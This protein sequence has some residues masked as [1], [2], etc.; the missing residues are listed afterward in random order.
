MYWRRSPDLLGENSMYRRLKKQNVAVILGITC[1]AMLAGCGGRPDLAKRIESVDAHLEALPKLHP[2]ML[3][4]TVGFGSKIYINPDN[5][6][7]L[8]VILPEPRQ[9]D[10]IVLIP[11]LLKNED[12]ELVTFGFP[13]R[14]AIETWMD[15]IPAT[16]GVRLSNGGWIYQPIGVYDPST[17]PGELVCELALNPLLDQTAVAPVSVSLYYA[18][19]FAP[20]N[21]IDV[22]DEPG[23]TQIGKAHTLQSWADWSAATEK[24]VS[25][26]VTACFDLQSV[27]A[28]A[29][30]FLRISTANRHGGAAVDNIK[31]S[32]PFTLTNGDFEAPVLHPDALNDDVAGWYNDTSERRAIQLSTHQVSPGYSRGH[33]IVDYTTADFPNPGV[34]PVV[35]TL[36]PGSVAKKVR[37]RAVRLQREMSWRGPEKGYTFA[38]NEVLIFDGTENVALNSRTGSSTPQAFALMLHRYYAVDGHSHFPPTNP[39]HVTPP[40]DESIQTTGGVSTL[41]FDLGRTC[42]PDEVRFYPVDRSPRFAHIASMGIGFPRHITMRVGEQPAPDAAKVIFH[43]MTADQVGAAPLMRRLGRQSGRYVWLRMSKGQY[44]PRTG[45][46]ALGLSEVELLQNGTNVLA[47]VK[48]RQIDDTHNELQ[49]LTD[50]MTSSGIIMPQKAWLLAL[51]QRAQFER[52]RDRLL[53]EQRHRAGQQARLLRLLQVALPPLLIFVLLMAVIARNRNRHRLQRLRERIGA[54]LH[55]E[56]GANL[57]SIALSSEVLEQTCRDDTPQARGLIADIHRVACETATEVRLLSRFLEE[58]AVEGD[59]IEQL[60]R[61]QDQMLHGLQTVADHDATEQFNALLPVE[62][63]E[64]VLFFKEA[65]HNIVKHAQATRVHVRTFADNRR[66]TLEI[67]DNGKGITGH[68]HPVHI[69]KRAKKLRAQLEIESPEKKGTIIRLTIPKSRRYTR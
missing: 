28:G 42:S 54:N 3:C 61:I 22:H 41:F 26:N 55:D 68:T 6:S 60:Q 57:S 20:A 31:L 38:L 33:V 2:D 25:R 27:P 51:H 44:D 65:L 29:T 46:E 36:P 24:Q 59:L 9:I 23:V 1:I 13:L 66:L 67:S 64:L 45:K 17:H 50:G 11:A 15:E 48:P 40:H 32:S 58:Q 39:E 52:E 53:R 56:V 47:G 18:N 62:K 4:P 16:Q 69:A 10:T 35:F 21:A 30:L 63:W 8:D 34:A 7:W 14:F 12:G 37:I 19:G 49:H 43:A 5:A